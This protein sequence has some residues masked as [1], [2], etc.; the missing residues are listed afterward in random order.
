MTTRDEALA[1]ALE[2]LERLAL[3]LQKDRSTIKTCYGVDDI[4]RDNVHSAIT[5][6]KQAQQAHEPVEQVDLYG[7]K[8]GVLVHLGKAAMPP[9]MKARELA[10]EQFGHFEDDDGSDADSCFYA[11]ERLIEYMYAQGFK[12]ANPAPKQAKPNQG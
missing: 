8:D 4:D 2:A 5:A 12:I 10:R 9:R 7:T 3:T 1:L 11:L 6:I